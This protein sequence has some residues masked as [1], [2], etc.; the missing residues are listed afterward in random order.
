M[1][2]KIKFLWIISIVIVVMI[3]FFSP[4]VFKK[5]TYCFFNQDRQSCGFLNAVSSC[6][7]GFFTV[8]TGQNPTS[9]LT[10]DISRNVVFNNCH[11]VWR[12]D[13]LMMTCDVPMNNISEGLTW[14]YLEYCEGSYK[15]WLGRVT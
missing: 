13:N 2:N 15:D 10:V 9:I 8:E 4:T 1:K 3:I 5:R 11:T 12:Q 7:E 14:K 6:S